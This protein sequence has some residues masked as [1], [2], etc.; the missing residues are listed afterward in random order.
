M[1]KGKISLT[2]SFVIL[3]LL[4]GVP[5]V[6]ALPSIRDRITSPTP[7]R[8]VRQNL[9]TKAGELRSC[10]AR[11]QAVKNRSRNMIKMADNMLEKFASISARTQKFYTNKVVPSGKT[12]PGYETLLSKVQ[13]EKETVLG[14]LEVARTEA[15]FSC[16]G[17]DP[18][19]QVKE[20]RLSLQNVIT[21]LKDYRRSVRNLIVAVHSV[22]GELNKEKPA[23]VSAKTI[24]AGGED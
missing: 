13:T 12:V 2:A 14:K 18:K 20:F 10:L 23:T 19:E 3:A 21:A 11:Q 9:A 15:D 7:Q 16:D 6:Q 22:T 8:V 1:L 4:I 5:S 17:D 24:N